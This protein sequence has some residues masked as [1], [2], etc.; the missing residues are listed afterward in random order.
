MMVVSINFSINIRIIIQGVLSGQILCV[1]L[2]TI[3][4]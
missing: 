2:N 3:T 1:S 4:Y